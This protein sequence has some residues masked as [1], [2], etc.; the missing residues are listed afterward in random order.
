MTINIGQSIVWDFVTGA[1]EYDAELL[2]AAAGAVL[3][4][5]TTE[6]AEVSAAEILV[7][8]PHGNDNFRVRAKDAIGPGAWSTLVPLDFGALPAPGNIRVV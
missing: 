3:K 1:V 4:S 2:N 6:D 5:V 8:Q 7:G